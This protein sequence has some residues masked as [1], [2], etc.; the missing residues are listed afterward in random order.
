VWLLNVYAFT[1]TVRIAMP[2]SRV[3]HI[4]DAHLLSLLLGCFVIPVQN[5]FHTANTRHGL[6]SR[7]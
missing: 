2:V 7:S 5:L 6:Q 3:P 1:G 4:E